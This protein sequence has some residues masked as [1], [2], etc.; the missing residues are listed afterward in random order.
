MLFAVV[1]GLVMCELYVIII[2]LS[3]KWVLFRK[4]GAPTTPPPLY[5]YVKPRTDQSKA[6][7]GKWVNHFATKLYAIF[8]NGTFK[9]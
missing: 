8:D 3:E 2:A 1:M 6:C 7:N 4:N 9:Q 5:D